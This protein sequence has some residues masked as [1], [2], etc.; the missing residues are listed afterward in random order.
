M[1]GKGREEAGAQ[2]GKGLEVA[3]AK[4]CAKRGRG[5]ELDPG[6]V[7]GKARGWPELRRGPGRGRDFKDTGGARGERWPSLGVLVQVPRPTSPLLTVDA[8]LA[9]ALLLQQLLHVSGSRGRW[10]QLA[11]PTGCGCCLV[12]EGREA[13]D[14][15]PGV[16]RETGLRLTSLPHSSLPVP[17]LPPQGFQSAPLDPALYPRPPLLPPLHP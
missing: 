16:G 14:G 2:E 3:R 4:S 1:G 5:P 9:V 12:E 7:K 15:G 8:G 13:A 6:R 11:A 17:L 10:V